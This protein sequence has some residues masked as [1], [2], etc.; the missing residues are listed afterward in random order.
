MT[1]D[2]KNRLLRFLK[3]YRKTKAIISAQEEMYQCNRME[4]LH[5]SPIQEQIGA[6][7]R[8]TFGNPTTVKA[9]KLEKLEKEYEE[10]NC[11]AKARLKNVEALLTHLE[12]EEQAV[13]IR[14]Y[15]I[16]STWEEL[17]EQMNY[18][19][20]QVQNIQERALEH[21]NQVVKEK[22]LRLFA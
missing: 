2:E 16:G 7:R 12:G 20:R 21:L 1:R 9:E 11:Q 17:A 15:I 5:S 13:L 10:K 8:L 6:G 22:R 14:K 19:E 18:S 3:G 4:I